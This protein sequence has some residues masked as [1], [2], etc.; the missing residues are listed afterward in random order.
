MPSRNR[1]SNNG[2]S[3]QPRRR[4]AKSRRG[5]SHAT[6]TGSRSKARSAAPAAP[7]TRQSRAK[8]QRSGNGSRSRRT[9]SAT[10][11]GSRHSSS[12]GNGTR[13]IRY[14]VIGLGYISQ[15]AVLPA[16][17]NAKD[18]STL[19]ALVSDDPQKLKQLGARYKADL[20]CSYDQLDELFSSGAIDAVYIALPNSMHAEYA[21]RA[22]EAGL[23]VLCEKPM[24]AT[25]IECERMIYAARDRGVKLMVAYRLHFDPANLEVMR[26][27]QSGALGDLR[28][29]TS[30]FSMQV[31]PDNIRVQADMGGGPLYD[32][33][34]YCLNAARMMFAAEPTEVLATAVTH[35]DRRF[36]EVPETVAAVMRFPDRRIASFTCSFGAAARSVYEVVGTKGSVTVDPAYEMTEP[37]AFDVRIGDRE[38]SHKQ[39]Q[40]DQFGPELIYFSDCILHDREPEPSGEE[41]LADVRIIEA[42]NESITSGRWVPLGS[43]QRSQRPTKQQAIMKPAV[44]SPSLLHASEPMR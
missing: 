18:N 10:R 13:K 34:I 43:S 9:S 29:F 41:G 23:H 16:F 35:E 15:V 36:T 25:A 40:T 2:S 26:L 32:I 12:T 38:Q 22:A 6:A 33:G 27:A 11:A 39:K 21:R 1:S 14:A 42:F 3:Q 30:Q 31:A 19:T 8:T 17:A 28:F 24:A 20:L 4:S 37:V 7:S 44:H 5:N